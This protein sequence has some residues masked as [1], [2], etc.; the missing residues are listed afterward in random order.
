[1]PD[2]PKRPQGPIQ[3]D[4]A[5]DPEMKELIQLFLSELPRRIDAISAALH[6]GDTPALTRLTHQLRGASAGYGYPTL[7][8]AAGKVEDQLRSVG[9]S[10]AS[11]VLARIGAEV[12]A[13]VDLCRRACAA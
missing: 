6:S 7:G 9:V 4:F 10:D 3:S 11:Q 1:M 5:G 12:N 13:L 2:Q 8:R